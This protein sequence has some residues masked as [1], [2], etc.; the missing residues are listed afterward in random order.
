[1]LPK[2][3]T[4]TLITAATILRASKDTSIADIDL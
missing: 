3:T 2:V 4:T 1:M